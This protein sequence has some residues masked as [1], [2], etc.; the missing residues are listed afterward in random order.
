[1]E[2]VNG[3]L[4]SSGLKGKPLSLRR[5]TELTNQIPDRLCFLETVAGNCECGQTRKAWSRISG[6]LFLLN[7]TRKRVVDSLSKKAVGMSTHVSRVTRNPKHRVR[8][9]LIALARLL[10]LE[11]FVWTS[12]ELSR[13]SVWMIFSHVICQ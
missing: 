2:R 10:A 8:M 1:M 6:Q 13:F 7:L 4:F 12:D 3:E 11:I 5:E 9:R